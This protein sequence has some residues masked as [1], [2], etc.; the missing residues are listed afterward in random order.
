MS[1]KKGATNF[2]SSNENRHRSQKCLKS[3]A[4]NDNSL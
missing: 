4:S 1:N 2:F 3:L